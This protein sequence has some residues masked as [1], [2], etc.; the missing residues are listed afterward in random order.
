MNN[1]DVRDKA[2]QCKRMERIREDDDWWLELCIGKLNHSHSDFSEEEIE[3]SIR[4]LK[5]IY[6]NKWYKE[7]R[8]MTE[9]GGH[10]GISLLGGVQSTLANI[11]RFGNYV[12]NLGLENLNEELIRR[13]RNWKTYNAA[14]VEVVVASCF[15]M[16][17]YRVLLNPVLQSGKKPDNM[18]YVDGEWIYIE[19]IHLGRSEREKARNRIVHELSESIQKSLPEPTYSCEV[20]FTKPLASKKVKKCFEKIGKIIREKCK[21]QLPPLSIDLNHVAIKVT[22]GDRGTYVKIQGSIFEG[23][24]RDEGRHLIERALKEYRQLPED[25][26]GVIVVNPLWLLSPDVGEG[27]EERLKGLFRP[28]LH[29]RVSGIIISNKRAERSGFMRVFPISIT[30]P[31][32]KKRCEK[33]L[34]NLSTA[35]WRY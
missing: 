2:A 7:L 35:L 20:K 34:E 12:A 13:L 27:M 11:L 33:A 29:T 1:F 32:A 16:A 15:K 8:S 26:P 6:D 10:C 22:K 4:V 3:A 5:K 17:G 9:H 30:N 14:W 21:E 18:V 31:F 24:Q 28:N 23:E 19:I 25:G